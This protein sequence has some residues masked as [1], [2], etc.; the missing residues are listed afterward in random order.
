MPQA[1]RAHAADMEALDRERERQRAKTPWAW[2]VMQ[3][4]AQ[5]YLDVARVRGYRAPEVLALDRKNAEMAVLID[6]GT[7][8]PEDEAVRY[9]TGLELEPLT[10]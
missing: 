5:R 6:A 7:D 4:T 3:A 1:V 9:L 10:P 2:L 8:L